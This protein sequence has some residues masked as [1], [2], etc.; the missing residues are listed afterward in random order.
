[1]GERGGEK[2]SGAPQAT[3]AKKEIREKKSPTLEAQILELEKAFED[4]R[5]IFET[6]ERIAELAY[7]RVDSLYPR[8]GEKKAR[9]ARELKEIRKG[10]ERQLREMH[11]EAGI[12]FTEDQLKQEAAYLTEA[13]LLNVPNRPLSLGEKI[14]TALDLAR[15]I[16]VKRL[17]E[18][19]Q[20]ETENLVS[21]RENQ[22]YARVNKKQRET[23]KAQNERQKK[24]ENRLESEAQKLMAQQRNNFLLKNYHEL[25][26]PSFKDSAGE[27]L[28]GMER[29]RKVK[30]V[31][32][33]FKQEIDIVSS[34]QF[35]VFLDKEGKIRSTEVYSFEGEGNKNP[36]NTYE[37]L[38][39]LVEDYVPEGDE[40][41][42]APIVTFRETV[43]H[44]PNS[45]SARAHTRG[46]LVRKYASQL[47]EKLLHAE[48]IKSDGTIDPQIKGISIQGQKVLLET[49]QG[50][51]FF[52]LDAHI[53][54]IQEACL[55]FM[56]KSFDETNRLRINQAYEEHKSKMSKKY[57]PLSTGAPSLEAFKSSLPATLKTDGTI[58]SMTKNPA[59]NVDFSMDVILLQKNPDGS[60]NRQKSTIRRIGLKQI[61][62]QGI[63]ITH[64]TEDGLWRSTQ[65]ISLTEAGLLRFWEETP[66]FP[67][68]RYATH[69]AI[70]E[71][72]VRSKPNNGLTEIGRAVQEKANE[73]N[74]AL[75]QSNA[76]ELVNSV[77]EAIRTAFP[78]TLQ[79]PV[80]SLSNGEIDQRLALLKSGREKLEQLNRQYQG[81]VLENPRFGELK[82]GDKTV[83]AYLGEASQALERQKVYVLT[84]GILGIRK[85]MDDLNSVN[86]TSIEIKEAA[87]AV[88]KG[89]RYYA[90]LIQLSSEPKTFDQARES[91]LGI[92]NKE[93]E[94]AQRGYEPLVR[95]FQEKYGDLPELRD[96]RGVD[97]TLK[98]K[99]WAEA[100]VVKI[101]DP[102]WKK[103]YESYLE[104]IKPYHYTRR[105]GE[106]DLDEEEAAS[107]ASTKSQIVDE[108]EQEVEPV[109][110][111]GEKN[112]EQE[113]EPLIVSSTITKDTDTINKETETIEPKERS[114]SYGD[115]LE[116]INY[117][118]TYQ[119]LY[120]AETLIL[121]TRDA[122]QIISDE[123][124][125]GENIEFIQQTLLP[126]VT[127]LRNYPLKFKDRNDRKGE[128]IEVLLVD[129]VRIEGK[130]LRQQLDLV[131]QKLM[132]ILGR[133]S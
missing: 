21:T 89:S 127:K 5:T 33:A 55:K 102:A 131:E 8:E 23:L 28:K 117:L 15:E 6:R 112:P 82:I 78:Q 16:S 65:Y 73:A 34:Y 63:I 98:F 14:R 50:K 122:D 68:E 4:S 41:D 13:A 18:V 12:P 106:T 87:E 79:Q 3:P 128:E 32:D 119:A 61:K 114:F 67:L 105:I 51:F 111:I 49:V 71:Q 99:N 94:I 104:L 80:S 47:Y 129:H 69:A 57:W 90:D 26:N 48:L 125:R 43:D 72:A 110:P 17:V 126:G 76:E 54:E 10:I 130:T 1:M 31:N 40:F 20:S 46:Q 75:Y 30:E 109:P 35:E 74:L 120:F 123:A 100:G 101:D 39:N 62:N 36:K 81:Y 118:E 38:W 53:G 25:V 115:I 37:T 133:I 88:E 42:F 84:S 70:V 96:R 2:P 92:S 11:R 22:L 113:F 95:E 52:R 60:I 93:R 64:P 7:Q 9:S 24:Y 91:L 66:E 121:F 45:K 27:E 85:K 124:S 97:W 107:T 103:K 83:F 132:E 44:L 56:G 59:Q 116:R 86:P 19:I 108:T 77:Q 29:V 58:V